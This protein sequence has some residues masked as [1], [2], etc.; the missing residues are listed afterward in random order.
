M[1]LRKNWTKNHVETK[2]CGLVPAGKTPIRARNNPAVNIR[3]APKASIL[4]SEAEAMY[5]E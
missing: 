3:P 2:V 1:Q 4:L 5:S